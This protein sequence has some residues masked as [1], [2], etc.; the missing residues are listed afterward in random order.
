MNSIDF[1]RLL[2]PMSHKIIAITLVS[3]VLIEAVF[4]NMYSGFEM[5]NWHTD[6]FRSWQL[7][8]HIFLHADLMHLAFNM[9]ALWMFGRAL[10]YRWGAQRFVI[11]YLLCGIGAAVISQLVD[12]FVL[13]KIYFGATI[14][15]S[16]AVYG[17]LVAFAMLYPNQKLALI[18]L[19]VPIPAKVFVPILLL[20]DLSAGLTGFSIFGANIAHFAHIGGAF[21]GFLLVQFWLRR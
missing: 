8:T 18:F 7:L 6:R 5:F 4:A 16:G 12:Q 2:A 13:D 14:G 9:L 15:A 11:F 3:Y 20:I 1:K 21:I 10:E 17:L 19:P